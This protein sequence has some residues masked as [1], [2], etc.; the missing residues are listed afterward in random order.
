MRKV[1]G[2]ALIGLAIA[3][4]AYGDSR[5]A[6]ADP[7]LLHFVSRPDLTPPVVTID[8]KGK[9]AAPGYI[10][11]APKKIRP[12][13]PL[14]IDSRGRPIWF[15]PQAQGATDFRVQRYRGRKVLTWWEGESTNG[16]S[17]VSDSAPGSNFTSPI[18]TVPGSMACPCC[19]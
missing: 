3:G 15:H 5:R 19:S 2:F 1:L 13:G 17:N 10:F 11:I 6:A 12:E 16:N 8:V 14:I 9:A 7:P 18:R 4:A